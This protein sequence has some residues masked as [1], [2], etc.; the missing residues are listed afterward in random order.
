M[1]RTRTI[2]AALAALGLAGCPIPQPLPDYP[3]GTIT[4]PRILVDELLGDGG[5]PGTG[6][7]G[8]SVSSGGGGVPRRS[9]SSFSRWRK[10][11][12]GS[13]PR[14]LAV[15]VRFPPFRSRTSLM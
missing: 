10:M 8:S 3:A 11:V 7:A 1:T 9:A 14:S 6:H 2:A 13:T 12:R 4:P 15:L 5:G